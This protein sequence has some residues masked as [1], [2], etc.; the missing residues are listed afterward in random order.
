MTTSSPPDG[1]AALWN[2][3]RAC[4]RGAAPYVTSGLDVQS[5]HPWS[6]L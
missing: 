4:G 2:M 6:L 3:P 5:Q 1:G